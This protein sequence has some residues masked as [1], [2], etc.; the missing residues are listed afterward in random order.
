MKAHRRIYTALKMLK[1]PYQYKI[2]KPT[3]GLGE[4]LR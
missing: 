1:H 2:L 3:P 4:S